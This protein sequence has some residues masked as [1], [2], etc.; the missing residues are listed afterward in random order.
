MR[1]AHW[2]Y[3]K[4]QRARGPKAPFSA[5]R[6]WVMTWRRVVPWMRS[7]ATVRFQWA[8]KPLAPASELN[9]LPFRTW[10]LT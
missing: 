4:A 6:E 5:S 10:S 8:R 7:E 3:S 1:K 9:R 2:K